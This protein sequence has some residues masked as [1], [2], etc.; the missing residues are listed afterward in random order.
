VLSGRK[1][2]PQK[3]EASYTERVDLEV[4]T[5]EDTVAEGMEDTFREKRM[6]REPEPRVELE[7]DPLDDSDI[8]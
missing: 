6:R 5:E 4:E 8:F 7:V 3:T 1:P 2:L